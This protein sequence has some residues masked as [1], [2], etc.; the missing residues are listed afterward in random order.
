MGLTVKK[1]LCQN[2]T[3][4]VMSNCSYG[5]NGAIPRDGSFVS[6][7]RSKNVIGCSGKFASI[8]ANNGTVNEDLRVQELID[9][10]N[11]KYYGAVGDGVADDT[12][13]IQRAAQALTPY[14]TL[15]FPSGEYLI[16]E[17][18]VINVENV[19]AKGESSSST[20]ITVTQPDRGIFLV[21]SR[22]VTIHGFTFS[23][24]GVIVPLSESYA[25]RYKGATLRAR[26]SAIYLDG[27][28]D[29]FRT[30]DVT[31]N[32]LING[33]YINGG[34]YTNFYKYDGTAA[35]RM[36]TTTF[37]L[38]EAD[39]QADDYYNG[40]FIRIYTEVN[41]TTNLLITD[42]DGATNTVTFNPVTALTLTGTNQW[43]YNIV[44][45]YQSRFWNS[46]VQR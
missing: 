33:M 8:E 35:G 38:N 37:I 31:V 18:I 24:N 6:G 20:A 42:Y 1:C 23:Y 29:N 19:T 5:P 25:N 41:A 39:R 3:H 28:A 34:Q 30:F 36:T 7:F 44:E 14:G 40:G 43:G 46:W 27:P 16:S 4:T 11:V 21:S 15:F 2:K 17:E 13:A 45:N 26:N 10:Q 22:D 12:A 32:N 9:A